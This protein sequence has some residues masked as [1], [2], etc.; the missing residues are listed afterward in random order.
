MGNKKSVYRLAIVIGL[1]L[2]TIGAYAWAESG[3]HSASAD[4]LRYEKDRGCLTRPLSAAARRAAQEGSSCR[5]QRLVVD[6]RDVQSGPAPAQAGAAAS[7]PAAKLSG[8]VV[9]FA[10]GPSRIPAELLT[11]PSP[12]LWAALAPG[13]ALDVQFFGEKVSGFELAGRFVPTAGDP[14]VEPNE[15]AVGV[16]FIPLAFLY[17]FGIIAYFAIGPATPPKRPAK[18]GGRPAA[19][20]G[21]QPSA[22]AAKR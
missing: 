18:K 9:T 22:R 7:D 3:T 16:A 8:Y 14:S 15:H 2:A 13:L 4:A 20:S 19:K 1:A 17:L 10:N 6:R 11:V 5:V 12:S 21:P